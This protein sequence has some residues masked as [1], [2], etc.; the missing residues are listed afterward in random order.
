MKTMLI[1]AHEL[2]TLGAAKKGE[3]SRGTITIG[4]GQPF[5]DKA[6]KALGLSDDDI[7]G[8]IAKGAIVEIPVP[9]GIADDSALTAEIANLN[10][11]LSAAEKR[12]TD[13]ETELAKLKKPTA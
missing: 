11:Q 10:E 7:A 2:T 13:A 3:L 12:A 9:L 8:L 4:A 1:A 5:D 6:Q